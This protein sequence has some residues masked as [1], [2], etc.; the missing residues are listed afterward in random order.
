MIV[1]IIIIGMCCSK[2]HLYGVVF[3]SKVVSHELYSHSNI[4]ITIQGVN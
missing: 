4:T 1:Q 3:Q 2:L